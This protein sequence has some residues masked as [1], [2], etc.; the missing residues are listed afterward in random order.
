MHTFQFLL[1]CSHGIKPCL[2]IINENFM[3]SV[4]TNSTY[5]ENKVTANK[6]CFSYI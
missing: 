2:K 5:Q 1:V 4:S 3:K 6:N